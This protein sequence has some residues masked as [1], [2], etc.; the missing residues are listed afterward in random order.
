MPLKRAVRDG[1]KRR[2]P[3]PVMSVL[4]TTTHSPRPNV[5]F[6]SRCLSLRNATLAVPERLV[7]V[8]LPD[9]ENRHDIARCR[10]GDDATGDRFGGGTDLRCEDDRAR[11]AE[12]QLRFGAGE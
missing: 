4:S 12:L 2:G 3:A 9:A 7:A 8:A 11:V 5:S 1:E 6:P 10:V